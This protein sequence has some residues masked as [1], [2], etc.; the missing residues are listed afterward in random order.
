MKLGNLLV[1]VQEFKP[2][3]I[4]GEMF[5]PCTA[6]IAW[7][8]S[9]PWVNYWAVAALEPYLTSLWPESPRRLFVPNP[10]SYF[11]QIRMKTNT[12]LMV[13]SPQSTSCDWQM[14]Q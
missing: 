1:G 12:Q 14:L 9:V 10:I 7:K 4:L 13:T 5:Y 6:L 8:L 2:D 3:L 11:P